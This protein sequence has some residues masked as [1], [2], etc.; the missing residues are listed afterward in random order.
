VA[1]KD[2]ALTKPHPEPINLK[3]L[4]EKKAAEAAAAAAQTPEQAPMEKTPSLDEPAAD[5][6][7]PVEEENSQTPTEEESPHN[8]TDEEDNET[9]QTPVPVMSEESKGVSVI[10]PPRQLKR[11]PDEASETEQ[12]QT[13]LLCGCI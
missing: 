8:S 10:Q 6:E 7:Q 1:A 11:S 9:A 2:G 13:G 5:A 12:Q 4:D 3:K